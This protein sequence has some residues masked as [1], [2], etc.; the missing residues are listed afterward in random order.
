VIL[1]QAKPLGAF[2]D[3]PMKRII[4]ERAYAPAAVIML[5]DERDTSTAKIVKT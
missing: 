3:M 5:A 2:F 1:Y 4:A